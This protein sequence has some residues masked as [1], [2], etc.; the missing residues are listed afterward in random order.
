MNQKFRKYIAV[1]NWINK[2]NVLCWTK[3]AFNLFEITSW[4]AC[5]NES[6]GYNDKIDRTFFHIGDIMYC[7]QVKFSDF[8]RTMTDFLAEYDLLDNRSNESKNIPFSAKWKYKG[9]VSFIFRQ[10]GKEIAAAIYPQGF[11]IGSA[12]DDEAM[13]NCI[14]SSLISLN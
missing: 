2:D 4:S 5:H 6:N 7:V 3:Y 8:D 14:N 10:T 1:V 9:A 11:N 13:A 12:N